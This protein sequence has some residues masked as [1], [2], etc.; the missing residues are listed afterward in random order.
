[1]QQRMMLQVWLLLLARMSRD[2]AWLAKL[3]SVGFQGRSATV[4]IA[5][6]GRG[7]QHCSAAELDI[8]GDAP[9]PAVVRFFTHQVMYVKPVALYAT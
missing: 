1:M 4:F 7:L 6:H 8:L 5:V 3:R 2:W 9:L